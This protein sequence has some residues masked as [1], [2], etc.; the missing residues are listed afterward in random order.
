MTI[1]AEL[2]D[3]GTMMVIDPLV[4]VPGMDQGYYREIDMEYKWP[5]ERASQINAA[6]L[7]TPLH[8]RYRPWPDP[9]P[10]RMWV[11]YTHRYNGDDGGLK[12]N[13]YHWD[14]IFNSMTRVPSPL[15]QIDKSADYEPNVERRYERMTDALTP[16]EISDAS[17]WT[18]DPTTYLRLPVY[19]E[20]H[21]KRGV[22]CDLRNPAVLTHPAH[23]GY[24]FKLDLDY[25]PLFAPVDMRHPEWYSL[26]DSDGNP[27]PYEAQNRRLALLN[28]GIYRL[29][30]RPANWRWVVTVVA[31]YLYVS[32][33]EM[34]PRDE[35]FTL[36]YFN[37]PPIY[38][39][40]HDLIHTTQVPSFEYNGVYYSYDYGIDYS[41]EHSR[42]AGELRRQILDAQWW[43]MSEAY[44]FTGNDPATIVL[45]MW[46]PEPGDI[47]LGIGEVDAI[48]GEESIFW[49]RQ[50]RDLTNEYPRTVIGQY[51][52]LFF[53]ATI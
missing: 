3:V 43:T 22:S 53:Q 19:N 11:D 9:F 33:F 49:V 29:Y 35:Y 51:I 16:E 48:T 40:R 15:A 2:F 4:K 7:N 23:V 47:V 32:W 26:L 46:P 18:G 50:D 12:T 21:S 20:P 8:G 36:S 34:I 38:P 10:W 14:H 45:W 52:A 31:H 24:E 6:F 13:L 17:S 44:V 42:G 41:F 27:L 39:I 28:S 30:L 37:R 25:N 1:W 5:Q